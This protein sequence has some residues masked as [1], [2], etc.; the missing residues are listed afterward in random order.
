M[1]AADAIEK[2]TLDKTAFLQGHKQELIHFLDTAK[3][4]EFKWHLV[5]LVSRL[6]LSHTD[7]ERVWPKLTEWATDKSESKIVRVNALQAL[8]ELAAHHKKWQKNM[9]PIVQQLENENI[10]SINARLKKLK[11]NAG[12]KK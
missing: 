4:K 12:L 9:E 1:R 10:P 6:E 2:I 11:G 7:L 8:Y 5:L 3:D